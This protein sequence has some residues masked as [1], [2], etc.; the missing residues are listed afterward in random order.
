MEEV[1]SEQTEGRAIART[2]SGRDPEHPVSPMDDRKGM[3]A[4]DATGEVGRRLE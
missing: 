2:A 3:P 4:P 1:R